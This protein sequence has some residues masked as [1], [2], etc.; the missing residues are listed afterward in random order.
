MLKYL[1]LVINIINESLYE[2]YITS[3]LDRYKIF[4]DSQKYMKFVY[5]RVTR[6]QFKG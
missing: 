6:N 1:I 5:S 3:V 4:K 2:S